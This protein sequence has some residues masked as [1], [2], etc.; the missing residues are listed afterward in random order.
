[1]DSAKAF[2][3]KMKSDEGFHNRVMAI[4]GV[5]ERLQFMSSEGFDFTQDEIKQVTEELSD[6]Q[7]DAVAGGGD[8]WLDQIADWGS[9]IIRCLFPLEKPIVLPY[10][11]R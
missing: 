10:V 7:L 4:K 5:D 9:D 6:E 1:M 3:E 8:G 2:I 11:E